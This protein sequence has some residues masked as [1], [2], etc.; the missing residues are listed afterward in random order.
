MP[1][2]RLQKVLA[3]AG[4]ASR[5]ACE[6]M[7]ADGRVWVNG[8]LVTQPG[9]RADPSRDTITVD[10][11]PI[12]PRQ[13]PVFLIVHKPAGYV[14]TARDD[15]GRPSVLDLVYKTRERVFPVGRLDMDS[16]GLLLLTN[17]GEL[18]QRLTHPRHEVEKEYLALV[19]GQP[20]EHALRQLRRG[21]DLDG[22]PTAPADVEIVRTPDGRPAPAGR[23]WLRLVLHE[24][25]KRQVRLMCEA[26]GYPVERLIRVRI[27]PLRLRGLVPGRVRELTD[28]EVSRLRA[29]AGLE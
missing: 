2:K 1:P 10:G 18:A 23:S 21:I 24:G 22:R 16:E 26:A 15:R 20:D 19:R 5:R 9:S 29:A 3:G 28:D 6:Q 7:I 27:G 13:T 8:R 11:I 14:T 12:G 25:R 17:D 4:I